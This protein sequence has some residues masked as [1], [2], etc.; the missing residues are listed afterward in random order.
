MYK[1]LLWFILTSVI[2]GALVLGC[3]GPATDGGETEPTAPAG[4]AEFPAKDPGEPLTLDEKGTVTL[5]RDGTYDIKVLRE[6]G[7]VLFRLVAKKGT[8]IDPEIDFTIQALQVDVPEELAGEYVAVGDYAFEL[9][10]TDEM[11]Y[12][13]SLRPVLEVHINEQELQAA[14]E[15]GG[16]V[17]TL[18]GN[19]VILFKEQRA[20]RWVTQTSLSWDEA[21]KIVTVSNIASAGT[22]RLV[23][24]RAP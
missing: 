1:R 3:G 11:G 2:A 7:E 13:F 18:K 9:L 15:A 5:A 24:K 4:S 20:P 22:F 21:A 23:A 17:D 8:V 14:K 19:V 6:N 16:S 12:G 10:A